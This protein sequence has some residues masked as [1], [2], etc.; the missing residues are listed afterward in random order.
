MATEIIDKSL[1]PL[2]GEGMLAVQDRQEELAHLEYRLKTQALRENRDMD[3]LIRDAV[4]AY[5]DRP[6]SASAAKVSFRQLIS[7]PPLRSSIAEVAACLSEEYY[8]QRRI[9]F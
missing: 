1:M 4:S 6:S 7:D 2:Y 5:L 9:R 3:E 8:G